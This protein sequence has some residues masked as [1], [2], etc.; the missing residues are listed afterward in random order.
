M[1]STILVATDGSEAAAAAER[2]GTELATRLKARLLGIS[3][4]LQADEAD[5]LAIAI[6]HAQFYTSQQKT[7]IATGL[8]KRRRTRRR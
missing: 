8:L 3:Q 4:V 1:T 6:C 5:G 2:L 7:G